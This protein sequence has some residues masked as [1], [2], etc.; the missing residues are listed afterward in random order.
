MQ[1][2][3]TAVLK[4]ERGGMQLALF[5]YREGLVWFHGRTP[6]GRPLAT[7]ETA[8]KFLSDLCEI[9]NSALALALP[10]GDGNQP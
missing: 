1:R 7:T 4:F 5:R 2:V 10:P 6:F 8:V 3:G 9:Y